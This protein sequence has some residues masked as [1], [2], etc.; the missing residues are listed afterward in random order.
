MERRD[1]FSLLEVLKG[2]FYSSLWFL[3]GLTSGGRGE[4][5]QRKLFFTPRGE[6]AFSSFLGE[7]IF[8]PPGFRLGGGGRLEGEGGRFLI[9][10]SFFFFFL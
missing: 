10:F 4:F 1:L 2:G 8:F 7:G 3:G 9:F 6:L 5:G